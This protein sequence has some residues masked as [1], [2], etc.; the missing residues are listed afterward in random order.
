MILQDLHTHTTF[1]DGKNAPEEMVLAAI[2]KGLCRIGFSG[3]SRTDFDLSYCMT[4]YA[5][6]IAQIRSLAKKYAGKIEILCGVEQDY[7][8]DAPTT[9]FD[10]VIGSVHYIRAGGEYIPIDESAEILTSAAKKHFG[11]DIYALCECYYETLADVYEKTHC[12]IIGHFDLVSKFNEGGALFDEENVRYVAAYRSAADSLAKCGAYFE[13]NS[14][15][16]A[17]GYRTTPYPSSEILKYLKGLGVK[18]IFSGDAHSTDGICYGIDKW[19]AL[20]E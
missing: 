6:Y 17:R 18:F 20:A 10:Y 2:S 1:C 4:D 15:A 13:I 7:Y 19:G 8:S 14:G 5:A 11:G 16:V 9:E 12:D 3:H